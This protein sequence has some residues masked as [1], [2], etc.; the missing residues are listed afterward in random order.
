[1]IGERLSWSQAAIVLC[2]FYLTCTL[3]YFVAANR[4]AQRRRP[5]RI[6][7]APCRTTRRNGTEAVP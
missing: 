2:T 4:K 7:R 5:I 1:M 3:A 6:D